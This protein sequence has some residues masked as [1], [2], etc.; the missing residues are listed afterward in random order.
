MS[1]LYGAQLIVLERERQLTHKGWT[2]EHDDGHTGEQLAMAAACYATPDLI[3]IK[4]ERIANTTSFTDPWPWDSN[5]GC[6][7]M[8]PRRGNVILPNSVW[9][10]NAPLDRIRQLVKAGALIAAEIDRLQR[11]IDARETK[12]DPPP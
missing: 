11:I 7:D 5:T 4:T 9:T 3:R 8:R 12:K 6:N 1:K 10:E 2:T